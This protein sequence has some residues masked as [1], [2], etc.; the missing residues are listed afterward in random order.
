MSR[1]KNKYV[2]V[3]NVINCSKMNAL[4]EKLV[5]SSEVNSG[6]K[7]NNKLVMCSCLTFVLK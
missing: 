1:H 2:S 5:V 7:D 6:S 4:D 3:R